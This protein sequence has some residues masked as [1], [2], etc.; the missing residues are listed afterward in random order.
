MMMLPPTSSRKAV[1]HRNASSINAL[2]RLYSMLISTWIS[3]NSPLGAAEENEKVPPKGD[4]WL[5]E[6]RKRLIGIAEE[7]Q[8]I[9]GLTSQAKWEG[10]IRGKWPAAQYTRLV[11][12]QSEMISSLAQVWSL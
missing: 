3:G 6:F 1:R 9:R 8:V 12:V 4:A 2:S 5:K 10:S 7:L 11:D